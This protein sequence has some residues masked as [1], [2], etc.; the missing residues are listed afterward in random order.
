[1]EERL[2]Q[3]P[4]DRWQD[5]QRG[6]DGHPGGSAT[7]ARRPHAM[8]DG[9]ASLSAIAADAVAEVLHL[10]GG[11]DLVARLAALGLTPG[12]EVRMVQ[13]FGRGP[14]IVMVRG[15]RLALGRREASRVH[16]QPVG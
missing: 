14:V 1:M 11:R 10:Y 7:P 12:V 3:N 5:E 6:A 2:R 4:I 9:E 15:T 16:V 13:N 8:L